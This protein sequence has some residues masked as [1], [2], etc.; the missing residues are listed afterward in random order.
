MTLEHNDWH[1]INELCDRYNVSTSVLSKRRK[2]L[3]IK[4]R[5]VGVRAFVSSEQLILLD[6]LHEFIQGGG[7]TAEFVFYRGLNP[8]GER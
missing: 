1:P 4:P 6:A 3:G 2:D 7:T 8:D 5:K